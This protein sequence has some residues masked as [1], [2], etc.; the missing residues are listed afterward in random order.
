M[1]CL[2][3][4]DVQAQGLHGS[5]KTQLQCYSYDFLG[6][7]AGLYAAC[8]QLVAAQMATEGRELLDLGRTNPLISSGLTVGS[9]RGFGHLG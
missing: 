4:P 9:S 6:I 7:F 2:E 5:R 3:V 1:V 8:C